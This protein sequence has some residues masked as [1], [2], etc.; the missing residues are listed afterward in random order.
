MSP[1]SPT[2][3]N[4]AIHAAANRPMSAM[5]QPVTSATNLPNYGNNNGFLPGNGNANAA[6]IPTPFTQSSAQPNGNFYWNQYQQ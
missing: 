6:M 4:A 5:S 1:L 3:V 2:P